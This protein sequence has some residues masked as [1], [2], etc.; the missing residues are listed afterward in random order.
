MYIKPI[1]LSS[2]KI[3]KEEKQERLEKENLIKG[4]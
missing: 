4:D 2:G 3:S 1:A